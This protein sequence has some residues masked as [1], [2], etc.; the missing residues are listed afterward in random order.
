MARL[1]SLFLGAMLVM[2]A[3]IA[4]CGDSER[5]LM[6][7]FAM[8]G[9]QNIL[10]EAH[11]GIVN[12]RLAA[13]VNYKD[14]ASIHGLWAP[15]LV[16][17]DF[18]LTVTILGQKVA[19]QSYLWRPFEVQRTGSVS[20]IKLTTFTT[21]VPAVRGGVLSLEMENPGPKPLVAPLAVTVSGTLDY[22]TQWEFARPASRTVANRIV[23]GASLV[24]ETKQVAIAVRAA[25]C[26]IDWDATASCGRGSIHLAPGG[27]ATVYLAFALGGRSEAIDACNALAAEPG[28]SIA[29]ARETYL[30]QVRDLFQGLPRFE[31]SNPSLIRFYNRSLVH[32]LMN[33]WDAADFV[34]RPYYATG[35][36]CG[37]CVCNYLWNFGETW[38]ILP[39]HDPRATREHIQQFL[40]TD[41]TRHFAFNPLTGEA[42]G[43]WYPVNQEKILGLIYYY[44][45]L[46]GDLGFLG[47]V[48]DGKTIL[49]HAIAQ[50]M[51]RDD[52]SR[53]VAL[54]DYGP[55]NSHLELRRGYPYNHKMPDLNGR[56]YENYLMAARLAE[57][58]GKPAPYLLQ[59]AQNLKLLLKQ[60]LWNPKTRWFDF[61]DDRERKDTRFT[62]QIFKLLGSK[63]LDAEEEAGLLSHLNETE[64]LSRFGLHSMSKTDVAYDQVDIDNG[65]GGSC[66]CFPPQIAERLYKAGHPEAA[67]NILRRIL[68]WGERMPYWGDSLVA[69]AVEYRKDTP[70]QCTIDGVTVAQCLIFGT[71]GVSV[72]LNGDILLD[73]RPSTLA[74]SMELHGLKLRG[75]MLDIVVQQG[76]YQV[77]MA[78][79]QIT[80]K[81]GQPVRIRGNRFVSAIGR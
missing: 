67:D 81:V 13:G 1:I 48:V 55:G 31:S 20:G 45:K 10:D 60:T 27:R 24:L 71:F 79:N 11:F 63:V 47:D 51:H 5:E 78:G 58:A 68:W 15:P 28:K 72:E 43:P 64:F 53:P 26:E 56:R 73:P 75:R 6:D 32:F 50:A 18:Q 22:T 34:L 70:L 42:F 3:T 57:A 69:N 76:R 40:K 44:V 7:R 52:R 23:H 8:R 30:G 17:S 49:D 39:L 59:R 14:V 46:T 38:E 2:V 65:G 74:S 77:R 36:V 66:T 37:G 29:R 80:A 25:G 54:I 12:G 33:R 21:L 16:S 61:Q 4:E 9:D 19:T 62:V 35:S 41:M